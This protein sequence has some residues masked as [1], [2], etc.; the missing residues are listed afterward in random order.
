MLFK[1]YYQ[2]LEKYLEANKVLVIYG[3]RRVGKT[4]LVDQFLKKTKMHYRL[5]TGENLDIQ[6]V[7]SS[8]NFDLIKDYVSDYELI[9]IDE[10]QYIPNVGLGLKIIVDQF[11]GIKI[12]AT[13]SSSF[14]LSGQVGEPLVGRKWIL[15]LY[16]LSQLELAKE[17]SRFDLKNKLEEF[18]IFGGYPTVITAKT[19]KLKRKT[20]E[21]LSQSYLLKDLLSLEQVKSPQTIVDL[22]KL[23]AFQVG[24]EVSL[25]E[26]A[27]QLLIDV[28]T[29]DRYLDLLEKTF[30]I[31]SLRPYFMNL[32]KT[33]RSKRKY[34]FYDLGIR[35]AVISQ[36]N[37]LD[38]RNDT[39]QLWENFLAMERLK[40]QKYKEM[41]TNNY[42]W[43]T[44]EGEEVDWAE[45]RN[46]ILHGFEFKWGSGGK[47]NQPKNW[48]KTY[49][50]T[51]FKVID[52]DNYLDFLLNSK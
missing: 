1:R 42:F 46:G 50:K 27:T 25:N 36:F 52:R 13:G 33:V 11:P 21:E 14:D 45:E 28:K 41:F 39:G 22:L 15:N 29:V 47:I 40:T 10:A 4:T 43:R 31:F 17:Y 12:I 34:Y 3:P 32:R 16:P 8:R 20:L 49:Q 19:K 23:L 9:V 38:L 51:T 37:S 2:E 30:V 35:N 18:L 24:N 7:L 26:L 48:N 6:K 44:W 5:D